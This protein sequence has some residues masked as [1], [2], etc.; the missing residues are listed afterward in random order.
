VALIIT[1]VNDQTFGV[2]LRCFHRAIKGKYT[3]RTS[4]LIISMVTETIFSEK[5]WMVIKNRKRHF[6]QYI[7][8]GFI[9]RNLSSTSV[10][11]GILDNLINDLNIN[12]IFMLKK[13][14]TNMNIIDGIIIYKNMLLFRF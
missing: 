1:P 8:Y 3:V 7:S 6:R 2:W 10:L 11:S 12:R 14:S 13:L 4:I 9:D 5:N